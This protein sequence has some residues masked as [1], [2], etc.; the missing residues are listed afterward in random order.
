MY[1]SEKLTQH[2]SQTDYKM[3]NYKFLQYIGKC[4]GDLGFP[5]GFL[6]RM[7]QVLPRKEKEKRL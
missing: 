2:G 5:D 7:A 3:E 1:L 4:Q 6:A